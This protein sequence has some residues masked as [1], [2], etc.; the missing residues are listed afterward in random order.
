MAKVYE[1]QLKSGKTSLYCYFRVRGKR[2]RIKLDVQ[3]K[4]QAKTLAQKLES[5]VINNQ[6]NLLVKE[7]SITLENLSC[8]ILIQEN[9]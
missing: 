7:T 8:A 5:D 3:N 9:C 1:R 4:T 2:Y 6:F